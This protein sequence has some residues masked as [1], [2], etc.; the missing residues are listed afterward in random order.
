MKSL[1]I[2]SLR[3]NA[4]KT[5]LIVGLAEH[6][7]QPIG[8]MKPFG[9]RLLYSKKRLWDYDAALMTELYSLNEPPEGMSIGFDH[10]KLRYMHT[11]LSPRVG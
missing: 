9:D 6:L 3:A 2:A 10:S 1:I 7:G 11:A 4:G 5:S 8:Y